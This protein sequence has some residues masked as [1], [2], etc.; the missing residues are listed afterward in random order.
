V[1]RT[2]WPTPTPIR[3][4]PARSGRCRPRR[5]L[6]ALPSARAP[7]RR[8]LR[9]KVRWR[10]TPCSPKRSAPTI[11]A[12]A[13]HAGVRC[14]AHERQRLEQLCRTITGPALAN[15]RVQINSAGQVVLELK[16]A[17]RDGTTHI[18]T[19]PLQFMQRLAARANEGRLSGTRATTVAAPDLLTLRHRNKD[20]FA[21]RPA[22]YRS[23]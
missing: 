4:M 7:G 19:P 14:Q 2:T 5:V 17:W 3:M 11:K 13:Q 22:L 16:T 15:E 12:T 18:V 9:C 1:D 21:N 8:F 6:T 23:S 20:R 10:K